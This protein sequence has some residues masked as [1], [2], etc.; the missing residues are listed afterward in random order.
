MTFEQ[1]SIPNA[2]RIEMKRKL[3]FDF[4][5][6]ENITCI[7]RTTPHGHTHTH[8]IYN[9]V[10]WN[11]EPNERQS[12]KY[13]E[14]QPTRTNLFFDIKTMANDTLTATYKGKRKRQE[15][16]KNRNG[17]RKR[18]KNWQKST[19][20]GSNTHTRNYRT[21]VLAGSELCQVLFAFFEKCRKNECHQYG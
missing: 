10:D 16:N 19:S 18:K 17:I 7:R 2:K 1:C 4:T 21:N 5:I 6:R 14:H 3:R 12:S 15:T 13:H 8:T 11:S 9:T 20:L